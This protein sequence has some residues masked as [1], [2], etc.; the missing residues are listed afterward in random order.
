MILCIIYYGSSSSA[1]EMSPSRKIYMG[2]WP[3]MQEGQSMQH[4]LS[5][6]KAGPSVFTHYALLM[7]TGSSALD[8]HT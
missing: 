2:I 6:K 5:H 8:S 7:Y 4:Q 1:S 3:E